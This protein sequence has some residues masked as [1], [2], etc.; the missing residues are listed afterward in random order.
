MF[1]ASSAGRFSIFQSR[2]LSA[3][4]ASAMPQAVPLALAE[5]LAVPYQLGLGW[6]DTEVLLFIG[7]SAQ[8]PTY[9]APHAVRVPAAGLAGAE[10]SEL[11]YPMDPADVIVWFRPLPG[12]FLVMTNALSYLNLDATVGAL[13]AKA[14][15]MDLRAPSAEG[16]TGH[17][18][19]E[20]R[21]LK[22]S[23]LM[24]QIRNA[25]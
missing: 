12:G 4:T 7:L 9:F 2:Y 8:F 21:Q 23:D 22:V 16:M 1:Q 18:T 15:G 5:Q 25:Q 3:L 17:R 13:R 19:G 14:L 24:A 11:L 6:A 20:K 10:L